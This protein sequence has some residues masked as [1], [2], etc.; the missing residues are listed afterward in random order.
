[1]KLCIFALALG[2]VATAAESRAADRAGVLTETIQVVELR[3]TVGD[4]PISA[5]AP[6]GERVRVTD[7]DRNVVM[8]LIPTLQPGP[9]G[10]PATVG[11]EVYEILT[12]GGHETANL[13]E[14]VV[15]PKRGSV[16]VFASRRPV[17]VEAMGV[18]RVERAAGLRPMNC[19]VSCD[20]ITAC[21]YCVSMSCGEC[22]T[23]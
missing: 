17:E 10:A 14:S 13:V 3:L 23:G 2:V 16:M 20:G 12:V 5:I 7:H 1:M 6:I 15:L 21:G 19:C 22:C 8:E 4:E 9:R 11:I 18:S